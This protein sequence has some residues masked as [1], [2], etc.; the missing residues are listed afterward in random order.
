MYYSFSRN[1]LLLLYYRETEST[2]FQIQLSEIQPRLT[3][4][5]HEHLHEVELDHNIFCYIKHIILSKF[6]ESS[7]L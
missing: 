4:K 2:K 3:L 5:Q 7:I 6:C 1:T